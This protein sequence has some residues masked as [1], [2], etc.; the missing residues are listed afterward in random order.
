M[1]ASPWEALNHPA[2]RL[3]LEAGDLLLDELD[4]D[5]VVNVLE[6]VE[7]LLDAICVGAT[8]L[9]MVTEKLSRAD[10]F[11]LEVLGEGFEVFLSVRSGGAEQENAANLV[12]LHPLK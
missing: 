11:P 6:V 5:F 4:H 8:G 7:A 10:A 9:D 1:A 12:S 2:L 3:L